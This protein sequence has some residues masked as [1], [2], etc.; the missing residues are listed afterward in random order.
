MD[1]QGETTQVTIG[2]KD[3]PENFREKKKKTGTIRNQGGISSYRK[4]T[5]CRCAAQIGE[6]EKKKPGRTP[7]K[8]KRL[9]QKARGGSCTV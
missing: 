2:N 8:N 9:G 1:S 3:E 6:N 7:Q 4:N 5:K